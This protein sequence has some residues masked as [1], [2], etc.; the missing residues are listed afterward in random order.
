MLI[1][2]KQSAISRLPKAL[3]HNKSSLRMLLTP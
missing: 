1:K 3:V 2:L